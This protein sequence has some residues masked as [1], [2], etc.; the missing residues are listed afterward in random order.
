M[1]FLRLFSVVA[2]QHERAPRTQQMKSPM[3]FTPFDQQFQQQPRVQTNLN[4][5]QFPFI[6]TSTFSPPHTPPDETQPNG[7]MDNANKNGFMTIASLIQAANGLASGLSQQ[8]NGTGPNGDHG[9]TTPTFGNLGDK[10]FGNMNDKLHTNFL[11]GGNGTN[12]SSYQNPLPFLGNFQLPPLI[13]PEKIH[14]SSSRIL[15]MSVS[16]AR[17]IPTFVELPFRD[18]AI[19]LEE[20]WS[21]LFILSMIQSSLPMDIGVLLSAAGLQVR[22]KIRFKFCRYIVVRQCL[23]NN[24]DLLTRCESRI[25]IYKACS[26]I[27]RPS[28]RRLHEKDQGLCMSLY[29]MSSAVV[30]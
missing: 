7:N 15:Y 25:A 11:N 2:V 9:A 21:E 23:G 4:Q 27:G 3:H 5:P 26:V 17:N 18:Q 29:S 28:L 14:E 24:Y 22:L 19:L 13:N 6:P 30:R 16:W 10:L 1:R 8:F 20:S 12:G